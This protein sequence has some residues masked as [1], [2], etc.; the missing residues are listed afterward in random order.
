MFYRFFNKS[1]Q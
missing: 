1:R